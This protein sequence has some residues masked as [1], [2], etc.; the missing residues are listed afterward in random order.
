MKKV[1][2]LD[3]PKCQNMI[4]NDEG[5]LVKCNKKQFFEITKAYLDLHG[6]CRECDRDNY[7]PAEL[8]KRKLLTQEVV[9]FS[10]NIPGIVVR[11]V[12]TDED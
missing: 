6:A 10:Y 8:T 7:K 1:K 9:G 2:D 12:K 3:F 5:K 4:R 11:P